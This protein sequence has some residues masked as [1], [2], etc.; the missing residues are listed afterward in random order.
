MVRGNVSPTVLG[1]S[2]TGRWVG[3]GSPGESKMTFGVEI[4]RKLGEGIINRVPTKYVEGVREKVTEAC[5]ELISVGA[6][7]RPLMVDGKQRGWVRGFHDT[8]RRILRRWIPDSLE[9]VFRCLLLSTTLNE[10]ELG[11]LSSLEIHRLVQL[12]LAMG[13]RDASLFPYLSAFSTTRTSEMLWHS[14]SAYFSCETRNINLPDG[15]TMRVL[16]PSNHTRLWASLCTY[17]EQAKKRLDESWNAVLIMRPWAGKSVDGLAA[18]LKDATRKM[19]VDA[20]EPWENVV[21]APVDTSLEDGW[22]HVENMETKEGMLKEFH[23]ML[24]NDRH[25]KLMAKFEKQQVDA[26]EQRKREIEQMVTRRGG[27]GIN[28]ETIRIETEEEVTKRE[29]DLQKGRITPTPVTREGA[30]PL[31]GDVR[32]KIRRYQQD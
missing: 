12:I 2:P 30:N 15:K 18:E 11:S 26:A 29:R 25:E 21:A 1:T 28:K 13:D 5:D 8:E 27:I 4:A 32:E 23:G 9:F 19:R 16:C 7:I 14:H 17:R 22:A 3:G 24:S 31:P 10:E 6:R 20:L